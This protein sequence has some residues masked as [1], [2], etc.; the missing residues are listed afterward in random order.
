MRGMRFTQDGFV[1]FK[2]PPFAT[3]EFAA[4]KSE[5]PDLSGLSLKPT[6]KEEQILRLRVY[7]HAF[8]LAA[9]CPAMRPEHTVMATAVPLPG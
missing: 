5:S 7:A 3:H 1:C 9:F 2:Q 4:S 6:V 8:S